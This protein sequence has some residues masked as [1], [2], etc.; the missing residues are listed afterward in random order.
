M[1]QRWK[2]GNLLHWNDI[3]TKIIALV[4]DLAIVYNSRHTED[5]RHFLKDISENS[6]RP[7]DLHVVL[8]LTG[9][10]VALSSNSA[11]Y[12][13]PLNFVWN[14]LIWQNSL[15]LNVMNLAVISHKCNRIHSI[16]T[17]RTNAALCCLAASAYTPKHCTE[18]GHCTLLS[19]L[20]VSQCHLSLTLQSLTQFIDSSFPWLWIF[21]LCGYEISTS[22]YITFEVFMAVSLHCVVF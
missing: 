12:T 19:T 15:M 5:V 22:T 18:S 6:R 9:Q 21:L 1:R 11:K 16:Q 3:N 10:V 14:V 17:P 13:Y 8:H 2:Y 20:L 4:Q 7:R